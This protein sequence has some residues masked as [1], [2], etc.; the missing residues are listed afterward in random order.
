MNKC[1][2]TPHFLASYC[3]NEFK[4]GLRGASEEET[5]KRLSAI[6]NVFNCLHARDVFLRSYTVRLVKLFHILRNFSAIDC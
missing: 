5:E 4:K 3:D 1:N 2:Y 6:I